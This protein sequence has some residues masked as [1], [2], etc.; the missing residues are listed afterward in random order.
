V[1]TIEELE[2]VRWRDPGPPGPESTYLVRRC[3]ELR[4]TPLETFTVEDLRIMLGQQIA[5]PILLPMALA[6]L[7]EDPLAEGN[8]YPG[9][10]LLAVLR[11]PD[12]VWRDREEDHAFLTAASDRIAPWIER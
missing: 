5:V 10:L 12:D 8:Y 6:V 7:R 1:A 9:D 11:L 3:H 2:G 4:R